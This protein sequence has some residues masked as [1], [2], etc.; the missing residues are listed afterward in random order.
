[1]KF[2]IVGAI[3]VALLLSGCSSSGFVPVVSLTSPYGSVT[4]GGSR[5]SGTKYNSGFDINNACSIYK[6]NPSWRQDLKRVERKWGVPEHI[7]LAIIKQESSFKANARPIKNG[8]VLSSA[9]G[10]SQALKGTWKTYQRATGNFKHRR[11][12]FGDSVNFMGW[13]I[14]ESHKQLRISKW[15]ISSIYLSY[16]EGWGGYKK[17]TYRKKPWLVKIANKLKD[18]AWIYKKQLDRC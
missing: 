5:S 2:K 16:H 18:Q 12:S 17:R 15:D 11:D 3:C 10:Y 14:N 8:K 6:K 4:F 7:M 13:Y 1:M 9:L